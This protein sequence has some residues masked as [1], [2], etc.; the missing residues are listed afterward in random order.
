MFTGKL[1]PLH[2][3]ITK[4][5]YFHPSNDQNCTLMGNISLKLSHSVLRKNKRTAYTDKDIVDGICENSNV[6]FGYIYKSYYPKIKS[7]VWSFRNTLLQPDD[8]F[9][10]GLT[11]VV[12]NIRN[13]KFR[14]DS[15]FYTYLNSTC[16]NVCLKELSKHRFLPPET[17]VEYETG[18]EN[19][20]LLGA[21][22][23]LMHRL[24]EKCRT[25]IDLRFNI[26]AQNDA[27]N[28]EETRKSTPFETV[29]EQTGLSQ[30]NARQ[31]FKRCIDKLREMVLQNPEINEYYP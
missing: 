20:E 27:E 16:R 22:V 25:I 29:A 18:G 2:S 21:L 23:D 6:V 8:V 13:G 31:R 14:G 28:P 12:M 4:N 15:S 11:R 3:K 26:S 10:E 24:D 17:D 5:L 7:M 9:Q 19:Y 30:A 1:N